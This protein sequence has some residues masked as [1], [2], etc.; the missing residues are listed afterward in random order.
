MK[1]MNVPKEGI[2]TIAPLPPPGGA[3]GGAPGAGMDD[4][5][6]PGEWREPFEA[7]ELPE[8]IF[9]V[10]PTYPDAARKAGIQGTVLLKGYIR[11][12][13]TPDS[14]RVLRSVA[15]LDSAAVESVRQWRFRPA[16]YRGKP[17]AVWVAIPVKF[18][19]H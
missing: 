15:G 5:Q 3:P 1:M 7:D 8:P 19:L 14:V 17:V 13:G 12:D 6:R 4:P 9:T 10:P 2:T 11:R 16:R 18:T